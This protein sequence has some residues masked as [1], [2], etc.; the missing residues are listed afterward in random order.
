MILSPPQPLQN[1]YN[2]HE[3]VIAFATAR[4]AS[5]LFTFQRDRDSAL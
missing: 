4:S 5:Y 1:S 3:V 2:V